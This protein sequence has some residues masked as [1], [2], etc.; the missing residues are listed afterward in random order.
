M[1]YLSREPGASSPVF[2][3]GPDSTRKGINLKGREFGSIEEFRSLLRSHL[4]GRPPTTV[5]HSET[6]RRAASFNCS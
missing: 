2:L 6:T 5:R 3:F 4:I 1:S